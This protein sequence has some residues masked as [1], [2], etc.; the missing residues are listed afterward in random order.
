MIDIDVNIGF[1]IVLTIIAT[2]F[3]IW[4]VFSKKKDTDQERTTRHER[5]EGSMEEEKEH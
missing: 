2:A 5:I 3:L 1:A 4:L